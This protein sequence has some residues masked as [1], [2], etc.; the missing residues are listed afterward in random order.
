MITL[1][2][3]LKSRLAAA[4]YTLGLA[5]AVYLALLKFYSLPCVGPGSCQ[6]ILYSMFGSVYHVPVGVYGA[7]L[8]LAI[9]IIPDEDKRTALLLIMAAGTAVFMVIQFIVLRGFC[10]YCTLHA[11]AAWGALALH[12]ERPRL[13]YIL[14]AFALAGGG[15]YASRQHAAAHAQTDTARAPSL[16][17][18]ADDRS[19]LPWLGPI[20]PRSPSLVLSLDCAACLDLLDQLTRESYT[21]RTSG[22]ALFLKTTDANR[23]LTLEFIAAVLAQRDLHRREAFLAV[24]TVLVT[25]KETA[26]ADPAAATAR[27]AAY[28]PAAASQ[29]LT[30]E[31]IVAAQSK[32]LAE[33]RLGDTTPLLISRD[34]A[35]QAF[36][37]PADLFP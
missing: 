24:L 21:G 26:L 20:W 16:S 1:S 7:A 33:T 4:C 3:K 12:R 35:T 36:I 9:I 5:L 25:D 27:L 32:V 15:F 23:A 8:W 13:W 17:V 29:M 31:K 14:L 10:P 6:A 2:P 28:F 22:P 19:A 37:K 11:A 18:L 30:A 34:G